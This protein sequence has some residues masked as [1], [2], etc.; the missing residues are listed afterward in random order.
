VLIF[1]PAGKHL[2]T[3]LTGQATANVTFGDDGSTLY[4]MADGLIARVKTKTA[5]AGF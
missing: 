3:L 2:G 1:S 4:I 5:G